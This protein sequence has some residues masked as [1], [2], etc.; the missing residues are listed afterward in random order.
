MLVLYDA[1]MDTFEYSDLDGQIS[2]VHGFT[3]RDCQ[4][5]LTISGYVND[6][7]IWLHIFLDD[8]HTWCLAKANGRK[9]SAKDV[10]TSPHHLSDPFIEWVKELVDA[11][12]PEHTKY[13]AMTDEEKE[14]ALLS[15]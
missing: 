8:F 10:F 14:W 5:H 15:E 13:L 12:M 3:Y 6:S 1:S 11:R 7:A 2:E 9:W 4:I